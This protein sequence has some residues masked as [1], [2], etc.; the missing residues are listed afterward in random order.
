MIAHSDYDYKMKRADASPESRESLIGRLGAWSWHHTGIA[1]REI[2][3][4]IDHYAG[5]LGFT[6]TFEARA[7]TDLISSITGVPGLGAHL[8]QTK[9]PM[10][11]HV[12][13]FVE[14][15]N[16]PSVVDEMLPIFPGRSHTAFL[17]DDI[18][19]ATSDLV[20]SGGVV[21]GRITEFSEGRAVYCAD[22]FGTVIELEELRA[23]VRGLTQG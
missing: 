11:E 13:E 14:F 22:R 2:D 6:I 20:A 15:F 9:S 23:D 5:N 7:M 19:R 10:S 16:L 17:V 8:V 3:R 21:L 4:V 1:V 12:L 18:E